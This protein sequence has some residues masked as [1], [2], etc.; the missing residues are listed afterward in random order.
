[1]EKSLHF[2]SPE[3]GAGGSKPLD[4]AAPGREPVVRSP[5]AWGPGRIV[6]WAGILLSIGLLLLFLDRYTLGVSEFISRRHWLKRVADDFFDPLRDLGGTAAQAF[7][8]AMAYLLD[9]RRRR[10]FVIAAVAIGLTALAVN[11]TKVFA[12]RARPEANQGIGFFGPWGGVFNDKHASFPSGHTASAFALATVIAHVY[13]RARWG[14]YLLAAGCG[15]ARV[16]EARHFP[17][18]VYVGALTGMAIARFLILWQVKRC[19]RSAT[20]S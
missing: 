10:W 16:V 7:I 19:A 13:P 17:T 4:A 8:L 9:R 12:G 3:A 14:A 18:D 20:G 5:A 1:M 15:V 6:L 11:T 2:Q